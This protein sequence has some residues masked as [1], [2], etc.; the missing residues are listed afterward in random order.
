MYLVHLSYP[1]LT[2]LHRPHPW[3]WLVCT[4][5]IVHWPKFPHHF[6]L[7]LHR[8]HPWLL[9]IDPI[10]HWPQASPIPAPITLL[11]NWSPASS[12]FYE[13]FPN[14][15]WL[16]VYNFLTPNPPYFI[17]EHTQQLVFSL[18]IQSFQALF[19]LQ[20]LYLTLKSTSFIEYKALHKN[21]YT[22]F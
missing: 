14:N 9:L 5:Y 20:A 2:L 10:A 8:S 15:T 11:Q 22:C 12:K 18:K 6:T 16:K 4:I 1:T 13:H 21:M 19:K 7:I 17:W 3:A